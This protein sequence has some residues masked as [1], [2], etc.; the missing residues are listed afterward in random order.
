V[1]SLWDCVLPLDILSAMEGTCMH[2][3]TL[4]S[5]HY[6]AETLAAGGTDCCVLKCRQ[7]S[8]GSFQV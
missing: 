8:L 6:G 2:G 1:F 7:I 3:G 5:D 4:P